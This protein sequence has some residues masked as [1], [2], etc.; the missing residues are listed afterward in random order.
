MFPAVNPITTVEFAKWLLDSAKPQPLVLDARSP[1]EYGVS[2]LNAAMRIDPIVLDST[3]ALSISKNTPIVVYCSIGYRS[4]KIAQ[5]LQKQGFTSIYNLSGGIF[6]WAN[7]G[8]PIFKD[9]NNQ[10]QFVHP[11]DA[12]WGKLLKASYHPQNYSYLASR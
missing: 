9:D 2:H 12:K 8:R 3:T 11:Y 5:Q 7:E 10:T 4:A 1:A 6:Q